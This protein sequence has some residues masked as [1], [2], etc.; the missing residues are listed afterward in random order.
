MP[1][2]DNEELRELLEEE[3]GQQSSSGHGPLDLR[4]YTQQIWLA[5]LGAFSK[6]EEE[7][8]RFFEAL[9]D[10]GKD[11][12]AKT[13]SAEAKVDELREKVRRRSGQTMGKMEKAFD[14]RLSKALSRLGLANKHEVDSLKKRIEEL[15]NELEEK[16]SK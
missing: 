10:T 4:K 8:G 12:E 15:Q 13:R 2:Q 5:G 1:E 11:L 7:G 9:V 6:A 3:D 14:E 16:G